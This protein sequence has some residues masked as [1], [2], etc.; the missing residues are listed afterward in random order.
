MKKHVV[1]TAPL[2]TVGGEVDV[3]QPTPDVLVVTQI[4]LKFMGG[5]AVVLGGLMIYVLPKGHPR[6]C[7]PWI[8][9]AV[10]IIIG[11][12]MLLRGKTAT[13][14]RMA[15]RMK[16]S[17]QILSFDDIVAVQLL[18]AGMGARSYIRYHQINLVLRGEPP[19]RV[20]LAVQPNYT[21]GL[22][23]ARQIAEFLNVPVEDE[24]PKEDDDPDYD[25]DSHPAAGD[26]RLEDKTKSQR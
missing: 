4:G 1:D 14:D 23:K 10:A 7:A 16:R 6:L 8:V 12:F 25:E 9:S 13:F 26:H 24:V 11:V 20:N 22:L 21:S 5:M 3:Q 18:Y 15:R 19:T 17:R 2:R